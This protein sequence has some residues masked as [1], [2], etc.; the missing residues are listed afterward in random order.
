V[1][2]RLTNN[3][4]DLQNVAN[5]SRV[6]SLSAYY[7]NDVLYN[8]VG[9]SLRFSDKGL[10]ASAGI[11][12]QQLQLKGNYSVQQDMPDLQNPINKTYFNWIPNVDIGYQLFKTTYLN[13]GYSYNVNEPTINELMPI[14]NVNNL[15]Y[16]IEGNPDLQPERSHNFN[17]NTSYWNQASMSSMYMGLSYQK[18]DNQIVYNQNITM[19]NNVGLQTISKPANMKGGNNF[20]L[21]LGSNFPLIKTKLTMSIN[22]NLNFSKSPTYIN[23]VENITR[24]NGYQIG[25]SFNLTPSPKLV[26]GVNGRINFNDIS[27]SFSTE[28]NQKIRNYTAN[29]SAK[30]QFAQKSYFETNFNYSVYRNAKLGFNQDIP[31]FNASLRQIFGKTN[32]IEMRLAAFDILNRNQSISQT[33]G[34]NYIL[35]SQ[36]N[37]LARYFLLSFSYNIKGFET[38]INK[39]RGMMVIM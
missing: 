14:T 27:Y 31:M 9:T 34:A 15:A 1:Q 2:D 24:N 20:S 18:Y 17:L 11:A 39:S 7:T 22:G 35:R 28:Q 10:N 19:V 37:T 3:V 26:L 16:K 29:T 38:K 21:Y 4:L 5:A 25:T 12:A 32:R 13:A 8:R 6:D 33:G 36:A 30:W 23:D